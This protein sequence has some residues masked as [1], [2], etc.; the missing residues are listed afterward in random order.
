M[1]DEVE[2]GADD[3]FLADGKTDSGG[4]T[5]G[6]PEGNAALRVANEASYQILVSDVGLISTAARNLSE[7]R[8]G[9]DGAPG[10]GDDQR[11]DTLAELDMI[12]YVGPVAFS[13]LVDYAKTQGYLDNEA[14]DETAI[15]PTWSRRY[16]NQDLWGWS[17]DGQPHAAA[18]TSVRAVEGSGP[19]V[20]GWAQ[21]RAG[22]HLLPPFEVASGCAKLTPDG[23]LFD[24]H[25]VDAALPQDGKQRGRLA[26]DRVGNIYYRVG[27]TAGPS[28]TLIEKRRADGSLAWSTVG[29]Y[30]DIVGRDTAFVRARSKPFLDLTGIKAERWDGDVRRWS[31]VIAGMNG[32]ER[33]AADGDNTFA[34]V[35]SGEDYAVVALGSAGSERWRTVIG[36]PC[37]VISRSDCDEPGQLYVR[38]DNGLQA[39]GGDRVAVLVKED[40]ADSLVWSPGQYFAKSRVM[41]V[42]QDGVGWNTPI[43][44]NIRPVK[45]L[46][47]SGGIVAVGNGRYSGRDYVTFVQL[48]AMGAIR[49]VRKG[50]WDSALS[51]SP[52]HIAD[53]TFVGTTAY[54]TGQYTHQLI[55]ERYDF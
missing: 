52:N 32:V 6:S 16:W 19:V 42:G 41:G 48:D 1:N 35:T 51:S 38:P 21:S 18:G 27:N 40:G 49:A 4:V 23:G 10:T 14:H 39:L 44:S 15:A 11:F 5:E 13:R 20:C 2:D 37:R 24:L 17:H 12:S 25:P 30:V 45:L 34:V 55:V 33:W 31:S 22:E 3:A 50:T 9:G 54:I 46:E 7:Y 8:L 26:Y 28:P 36:R 47:L 43:A 29:E 53:A